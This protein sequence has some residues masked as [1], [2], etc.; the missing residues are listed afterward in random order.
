MKRIQLILV[1]AMAYASACADDSL[2][3]DDA[4]SAKKMSFN[5]MIQ[6]QGGFVLD[7]RSM[8]GRLVVINA[9]GEVGA[10][11]V[12]ASTKAFEKDARIRIDHE[13]G[14]FD[15]KSAKRKGEATI[16][17]IS[18]ETL[19]V[20][21]V[22]ADDR[23]GFVNV[24]KL[25]TEKAAFF[26][27]RV[28]KEIVRV[29]GL[30]LGAGDSIMYP[31]C[32]TGHIKGLKYLDEIPSEQLPHDVMQRITKSMDNIG[33][34]PYRRTTYKKA[35]QEGWAPAPTNEYQKVVWDQIHAIPTEPM[36]IK[37][38]PARGE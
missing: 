35:C 23:W 5:E 27:A 22:A 1:I 17:V 8:K 18:D 9:Q 13:V 25:R 6:R 21:M 16:Y 4:A 12:L 38:D 7:T 30:V 34:G 10:D 36:K 3:T 37:F 11:T 24:A 31:M 33:I 26:Q 28:R 29:A 14:T 19:P 32:L 15:L 2:T 20:I